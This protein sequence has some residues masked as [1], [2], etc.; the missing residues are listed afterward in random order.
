MEKEKSLSG[1]ELTEEFFQNIFM[2]AGDGIFLIDEQGRMVEMNPR[3]CEILGYPKEELLGQPVMKFHPPDEIER[4]MGGLARLASEKLIIM[5]SAFIRKDGVRIPV[6]ITGKQLSNNYIIGLLRDITERK[7]A[8]RIMSESEEKFRKLVEHSPDGITLVDEYGMIVEWN[9]G[10]E[11]LTGMTRADTLGRPIWEVQLALHPEEARSNAM[12]EMF[13]QET[14]GL[15]R[16]NSDANL[17]LPI[18][19][20]IQLPDKTYRNVEIM[21]YTYKTEVG[22]RMGCISRDITRR[23][24]IE[25]L[26]E[27]RAMHDVLTDLPNRQLLQDRLEHGLEYH[28]R[29]QRG[30]VAVIM[31]DLDHFKQVNDTYGHACGDQVLKIMGHRLQ[32]CLRKS[33]TAARMGGDEFTLVIADVKNAESTMTLAQKI[34]STVSEPMEIE[35]NTLQLTASIGISLFDSDEYE[36]A[37]LLRHADIA[38]YQA[39]QTRNCYKLYDHQTATYTGGANSAPKKNIV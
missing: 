36:A 21:R 39:K 5:E 17:D 29:E 31:L 23:K 3:G 30:M 18:E 16:I 4:I 10:Q 19:K 32:S 25:L 24:Q 6:E 22:F 33:D 1:S 15:L 12:L 2:Q 35:G 7:Q 20:L 13:K 27:Y 14:F 9:R 28:K 8:E 26:L 37:T 34:L 11:K 38:L